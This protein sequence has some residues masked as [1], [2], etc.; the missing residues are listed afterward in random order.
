MYLGETAVGCPCFI[1][2]LVWYYFCSKISVTVGKEQETLEPSNV[3]VVC[4]GFER[5][6]NGRYEYWA[7]SV[8]TERDGKIDV[9]LVITAIKCT[10]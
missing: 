4:L 8:E 3:Y 1:C 2:C 6:N 10:V 9:A 5:E 7:K